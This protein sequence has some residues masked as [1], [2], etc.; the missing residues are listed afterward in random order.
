MAELPHYFEYKL[1]HHSNEENSGLFAFNYDD[2]SQAFSVGETV[3]SVGDFDPYGFT[4]LDLDNEE[5]EAIDL[6]ALLDQYSLLPDFGGV[7]GCPK[8]HD[9]V[10]E[11][12]DALAPTREVM[13]RALVA[14]IDSREEIPFEDDEHGFMGYAAYNR[15][16]DGTPAGLHLQVF[17]NCACM[18]PNFQGLFVEGF[19]HGFAEYDLHNADLP[20]QRIGLY[21]GLGH[22]AKLASEA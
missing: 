20:A 12:P 2:K 18:G 8:L 13:H 21:A 4:G 17:G 11:N 7:I 22:L 15:V 14:V 10:G 1:E 3:I 6:R 5:A 16:N 9:W 19:D